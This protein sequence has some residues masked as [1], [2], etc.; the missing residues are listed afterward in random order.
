[1]CD[2][3]LL[4][5]ILV[6]SLSVLSIRKADAQCNESV[7]R[8]MAAEGL[9]AA[10]IQ[11][12]CT[13]ADRLTKTQVTVPISRTSAGSEYLGTWLGGRECETKT[14]LLSISKL[15]NSFRIE[16]NR[17]GA[18]CGDCTRYEGIFTLTPQGV[19]QGR[20]R[21]VAFDAQKNRVVMQG[22]GET[23]DFEKVPNDGSHGA[24]R[25][26]LNIAESMR[27]TYERHLQQATLTLEV[28]SSKMILTA[29][30]ET[31]ALDYE[32]RSITGADITVGLTIPKSLDSSLQEDGTL[33]MVVHVRDDRALDIASL[34]PHAGGAI[35]GMWARTRR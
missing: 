34:V 10:Q 29:G 5:S 26:M 24:T 15:G 9:R 27:G 6:L 28:T 17:T 18:W 21:V 13:K 11:R 23:F 4:W 20:G 12:I 30:S 31:L 19:L 25:P 14:C 7:R 8:A 35:P 22:A 32:V 33:G 1:M 2:R 3:R 16:L